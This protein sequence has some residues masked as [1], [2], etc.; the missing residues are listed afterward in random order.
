MA[1]CNEHK[2]NIRNWSRIITNNNNNILV[3][4]TFKLTNIN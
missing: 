4:I 3:T 1:K 2:R